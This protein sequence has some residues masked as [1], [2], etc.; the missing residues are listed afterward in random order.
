[1]SKMKGCSLTSILAVLVLCF[2]GTSVVSASPGEVPEYKPVADE[3]IGSSAQDPACF[4]S[5]IIK[6]V[7]CVGSG[8]ECKTLGGT[9]DISLRGVAP[10]ILL[11]DTR[12]TP[13]SYNSWRIVCND[14][15]DGTG[16]FSIEDKQDLNYNARVFTI[17]ADAP[18]NSLY[19]AKNG[20]IGIGTSTP[21]YTLHGPVKV[22]FRRNGRIQ[23]SPLQTVLG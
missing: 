18:A 12:G 5:V 10:L 6:R 20:K 13:I 7:L 11:D 17:E 1:M 22:E 9:D 21:Y 3:M 2:I 23:D 4:D 15:G 19:V 8:C 16:Y 14:A